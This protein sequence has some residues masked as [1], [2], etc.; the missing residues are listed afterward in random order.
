[1]E[2]ISVEDENTPPGGNV[3]LQNQPTLFTKR[4]QRYKHLCPRDDLKRPERPRTALATM[5]PSALNSN[6]EFEK[7]S[8]AQGGEPGVVRVVAGDQVRSLVV[9]TNNGGRAQPLVLSRIAFEKIRKAAR[10]I[11]QEEK[12]KIAQEQ[13]EAREAALK[14]NFLVSRLFSVIFLFFISGCRGSKIGV[15]EGRQLPFD[16]GHDRAGKGEQA[17]RSPFD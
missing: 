6:P 4:P 15:G 1:M 5:R 8:S 14:V 12:D 16:S 11:S 7:R 17:T 13:E 2:A 9:P 3:S 10:V